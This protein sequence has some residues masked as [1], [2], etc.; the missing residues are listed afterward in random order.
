MSTGYAWDNSCEPEAARRFSGLSE[1]FDPQTTRHM[2][3]MGI[4][5][6]WSCLEVGGGG[7]S[8]A[9]W[10]SAKVGRSGRVLV[11]DIDTRF[12]D[13]LRAQSNIE[14]LKHDITKDELPTDKFDLA[15]ARLVLFH[16]AERERALARMISSSKH[17]GWVLVEDYDL[18]PVRDALGYDYHPTKGVPPKM[19]TNV[20]EKM[21]RA[22]GEVL[23]SHGADLT[24]ARRLYHL[25]RSRGLQEVGMEGFHT[26]YRGGSIGSRL[27][28]AN[29]LQSKDEMLATGILTE[30]EFDEALRL[31]DDPEWARYGPLMISVWGRKP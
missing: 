3:A 22:R 29:S 28:K 24:Y 30:K 31:M 9:R 7:G 16:L 15:H 1:I 2:E 10:L 19:S 5:A 20:V 13:G 23:L 18:G 25:F 26:T 11:T 17:G 6:G 14:V 27:D 12:L 8:I 21:M 4:R